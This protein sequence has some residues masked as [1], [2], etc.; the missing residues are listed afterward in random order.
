MPLRQ[1]RV[2]D[3]AQ[4]IRRVYR[5]NSYEEYKKKQP[6]LFVGMG[7][8]SGGLILGFGQSSDELDDVESVFAKK[9]IIRGNFINELTR[10]LG[11]AGNHITHFASGWV[12]GPSENSELIIDDNNT[13]SLNALT[14]VNSLQRV[15]VSR[16]RLL[17]YASRRPSLF[18]LLLNSLAQKGAESIVV[19]LADTPLEFRT[20]FYYDFY[21]RIERKK[22]SPRAAFRQAFERTKKRFAR[23]LWPYLLTYYEN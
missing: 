11:K 3:K 20:A 2:A 10:T 12:P 6:L 19:S 22:A 23:H 4:V 17:P 7:R 18:R 21:Y 13:L 15:V 16:Q 5:R 8:D 14:R 1:G 9:K